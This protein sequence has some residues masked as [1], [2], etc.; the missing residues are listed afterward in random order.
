MMGILEITIYLIVIPFFISCAL[1]FISKFVRKLLKKE[2][3]IGKWEDAIYVF[4]S[5]LIVVSVLTIPVLVPH[6]WAS[7][8]RAVAEGFSLAGAAKLAVAYYYMQHGK[9]PDNNNDAGLN[10]SYLIK[11]RNVVSITVSEGGVITC[12]YKDSYVE[13]GIDGQTI[14]LK[15]IPIDGGVSWDCTLGTMPD[16]YRPVRCRKT[17][18]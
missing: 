2:K 15:P 5:Y 17:K 9:F 13:M 18:E 6:P 4:L 14:V 16:K 12:L 11:G 7:G 1:F 3:K 8:R 10:E